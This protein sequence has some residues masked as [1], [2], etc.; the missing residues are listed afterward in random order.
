[1]SKANNP[2]AVQEL[3]VFTTCNVM[4]LLWQKALPSLSKE[5]K[6]WFARHAQG[7]VAHQLMELEAWMASMGVALSNANGGDS[8]LWS[9]EDIGRMFGTVSTHVGT[10]S[11]LSFIGEDVDA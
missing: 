9:Q 4:Y 11:A 7:E 5:E 2:A 10:L 8:Y 1:M 6:Q 3:P